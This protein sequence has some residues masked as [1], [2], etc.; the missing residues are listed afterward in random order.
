MANLTGLPTPLSISTS[1][2]IVNLTLFLFSTSDKRW[3]DNIKICAES[4]Y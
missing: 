1:V 4:A 3:R 2:S